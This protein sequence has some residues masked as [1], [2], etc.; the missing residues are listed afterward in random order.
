M[1]YLTIIFLLFSSIAFAE[2]IQN[3]TQTNAFPNEII[4]MLQ[5]KKEEIPL[6]SQVKE[7]IQI[8][9]IS[10]LK[11]HAD[12]NTYDITLSFLDGRTTLITQDISISLKSGDKVKLIQKHGQWHI[13][14]KID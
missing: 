5:S 8:G 13:T 4:D 11:K 7:I 3:L 10:S 6:N 9:I 1:R 12:N 14:E 2:N